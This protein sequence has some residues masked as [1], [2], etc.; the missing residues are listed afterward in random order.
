[1]VVSAEPLNI[2]QMGADCDLALCHGGAGT[3]AA[4]LLAGK[5]LMVFPMQM[6]QA[7]AAHR[8]AATGAAVA[9]ATQASA[10]LPR[11]LKKALNDNTLTQ[12]AQAFAQRHHGYDQQATIRTVADR[13]EAVA[14]RVPATR[15]SGQAEVQ[16]LAQ[17]EA[18]G[19]RVA[20]AL[21]AAGAQPPAASVE[22]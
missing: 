5:P 9:L 14:S 20:D 12:A 22:A 4:M 19:Q 6:E 18:L 21:R 13:G 11:L 1:M 16:D 15:A 8:L 10:Q 7:M 2:T 17:A 3:T